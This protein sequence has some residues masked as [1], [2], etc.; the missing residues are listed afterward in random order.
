MKLRS[1]LLALSLLTLLLPWSAWKL[2]QEV[3]G[4]LRESQEHA[5][6]A[7]A[8]TMVGVIPVGF[9]TRLLFLPEDYLLLRRLPRA[10][11]RGTGSAR[12]AARCAGRGH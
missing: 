3:E 6:F 1:K 9:Q 2:L 11:L 5:L 7:A 12:P 10:P 4:F 8:Q